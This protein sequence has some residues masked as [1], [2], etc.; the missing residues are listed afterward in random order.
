MRSSVGTEVLRR[1]TEA[2]AGK[3]LARLQDTIGGLV[4]LK[5]QSSEGSLLHET[6]L[7]SHL[8]YLAA[9]VDLAYEQPTAGQYA[10]FRYLDARA[11]AGEQRL[12]AAI[13][14]GNKLL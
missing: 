2:Q 12:R 10:V 3:A 7:R 1:S 8:A 4:Q 6:K 5:I 11:Q 9:D 14:D 13:A